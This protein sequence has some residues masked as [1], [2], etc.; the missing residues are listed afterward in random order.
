MSREPRIDEREALEVICALEKVESHE[1]LCAGNERTPDL[2]LS[3][4]G[5]PVFVEVTMQTS[6]AERELWR[7]AKKW[8]RRCDDLSHQWKVVVADHRVEARAP[9]RTLKELI[10][11]LVP[12]LVD[13]ESTNAPSEVMQQRANEILDPDPHDPNRLG[14]ESRW[15]IESWLDP[16]ASDVDINEFVAVHADQLCGYW[17]PPDVVDW[18]IE[19]IVP[20][21]VSVFEPPTPGFNGTGGVTVAVVTAGSCWAEA[22]DDLLPAIQSRVDHKADRGQLA[23][24][25]GQKWLVVALDTLGAAT[26]LEELCSRT[27]QPTSPE[28]A[29][30]FPDFD[31]V[32]TFA[33]TFDGTHHAVL[34]LS[35]SEPIARCF[36]VPR[37]KTEART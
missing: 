29:I 4:G 6:S 14:P 36:K 25:T 26:Q 2:E 32:W 5:K 10:E 11:A 30:A 8:S 34:R 27:T 12:V 15:W 33:R 28:L 20:R 24:V 18:I 35:R 31:E 37:S 13:I 3:I 21:R 9:S 19:G 22:A 16:T 1:W 23:N 7:A 17:H